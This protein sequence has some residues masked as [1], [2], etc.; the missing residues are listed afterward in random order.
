MGQNPLYL[1][2]LSISR[3]KSL[4][5]FLLWA[6][7]NFSNLVLTQHDD[8]DNLFLIARFQQFCWS[9]WS[10]WTWSLEG[11]SFQGIWPVIQVSAKFPETHLFNSLRELYRWTRNASFDLNCMTWCSVLYPIYHEN[12]AGAIGGSMIEL[13]Y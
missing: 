4:P 9:D 10:I 12:L 3:T 1:A 13:V 7:W 6:N 11:R 8:H 2:F 5:N